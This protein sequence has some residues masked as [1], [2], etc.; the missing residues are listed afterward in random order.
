[1]KTTDTL[2][3][4]FLAV[5]FTGITALS[6]S[7]CSDDDGKGAPVIHGV[8][9]TDPELA[10][11]TFTEIYPGRM[12][13]VLGEN[14]NGLREVYI[15]EQ[16]V[17]FNSSY[18]TSRSFIVSVPSELELTGFNPSLEGGIRVVTSHGEA[19][20]DFH[21]LSPAPTI[22]RLA[23][24]YPATPGEEMKVVG[25]NL[26]EIRQIYFT[27]SDPSEG[28]V[29]DKVEVTTYTINPLFT[30]ITFHIPAGIIEEGYLVIECHTDQA[31]IGFTRDLSP[32]VIYGISSDMPV[33][34]GEV[35]LWG[36]D[37]LDIHTLL[38]NDELMIPTHVIQINESADTLRFLLNRAPT[39][40]GKIIVSGKA[41]DTEVPGIFYPVDH[42]ILDYDGV[43]WY[44]WGSDNFP[45]VADGS[46]PPYLSTGTCYGIKGKPGSWQGWWGNIIN[47]I[48]YPSTEVIPAHTPLSKMELRYECYIEQYTEG[49]TFEVVLANNWDYY[50]ESHVPASMHTG[51]T[52]TG[53]W[54]AGSIPLTELVQG[55]TYQEL[56]DRNN[57]D[58]G[59]YT[60]HR[61]ENPDAV[62][63]IY[64]DNFRL[65][66]NE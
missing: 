6:V 8:R 5:L 20:Y 16:K 25:K 48:R 28:P 41:G 13:V 45:L 4:L 3:R 26:V 50:Q 9:L 34:G 40:A 32:C 49:I 33:I 30:E 58:F 17:G 60:K 12:I 62:L 66:V 44:S 39:R 56:L 55:S 22:S 63:E 2:F 29:T 15:N 51:N 53:Y 11:S 35:V 42:V 10:D 23:I 59:I 65:V 1:M 7:S 19:H 31:I 18:A 52:D 14:L 27:A 46:A 64:F 54:M 47:G 37:F 61:R 57:T 21:I 43:G 36:R 24:D 38:I